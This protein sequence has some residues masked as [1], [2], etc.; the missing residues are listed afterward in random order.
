[1]KLL[2]ILSLLALIGA[3]KLMSKRFMGSPAGLLRLIWLVCRNMWI[4]WMRIC[5]CLNWDI[6]L[7][8]GRLL[9]VILKLRLIVRFGLLLGM[10]F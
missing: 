7:L 3:G 4:P 2:R 8:Y 10:V 6:I 9:L 1:M 5:V